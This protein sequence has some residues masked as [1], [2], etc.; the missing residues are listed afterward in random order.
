M[1]CFRTKIS[2]IIFRRRRADICLEHHI[3]LARRSQCALLVRIRADD[4]LIGSNIDLCERRDLQLFELVRAG[5]LF[6][7]FQRGFF[8]QRFFVESEDL[9][10][11]LVDD[12]DEMILTVAQLG[13][14][15]VDHRVAEAADV[16]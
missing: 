11:A 4:F 2:D 9:A 7:F 10:V 5:H 14:F 6:E 1:R 15:A 3:E 16:T 8:F 12:G 13:D